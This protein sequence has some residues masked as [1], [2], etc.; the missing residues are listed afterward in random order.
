MK[1]QKKNKRRKFQSRPNKS[2]LLFIDPASISSGW[3]LYEGSTCVKSGTFVV[4]KNL[5]IAVRLRK[6]YEFYKKLIAKLIPEEVHVEQLVRA[7]HIYTHWSVGVILASSSI[8]AFA[9]INITSWQRY[10]NW[11]KLAKA[12][13]TDEAAAIEMGK[14]YVSHISNT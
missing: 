14:Y 9:D 4:D 10:T 1:N 12:L 6:V 5:P 13:Q 8:P 7:T 2:K 3:A 11:K